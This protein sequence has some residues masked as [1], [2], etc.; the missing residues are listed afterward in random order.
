MAAEIEFGN[1]NIWAADIAIEAGARPSRI[2]LDGEDAFI[3]DQL[4]YNL[5]ISDDDTLY[6][7]TG[8]RITNV[9][10]RP[11][12][13]GDTV[14]V[15]YVVEDRRWRWWETL[16]T[17]DYNRPKCDGTRHN[18]KTCRQMFDELLEEAG[19]GFF[20]TNWASEELYPTLVVREPKPV[21]WILEELCRL[22]HHTIGLNWG[23]FDLNG[24]TAV[25]PKGQG[26]AFSFD[27]VKSTFTFN[28]NE[29][30]TR[31]IVTQP[32]ILESE[33]ELDP[34]VLEADGELVDFATCS[35]APA[36]WTAEWP[37]H[38]FGVGT[39]SQHLAMKSAY[40]LFVPGAVTND[41]ESPGSTTPIFVSQ[42]H[43]AYNSVESAVCIDWI[44][45][46]FW[47]EGH[48]GDVTTVD[49]H[50]IGDVRLDGNVFQFDSPVFKVANGLVQ[51]PTL[52]AKA[53]H[54]AQ[55]ED[56]SL[57]TMSYG[58]GPE[59]LAEW[60]QP[61]AIHGVGTNYDDINN[62]LRE[63]HRILR[64][65]YSADSFMVVEDGIK[66]AGVDGKI[67]M[68]RHKVSLASSSGAVDTEIYYGWNWEGTDV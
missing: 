14:G 26:E 56:G 33:I 6:T 66:R 43:C 58:N 8:C 40:K 55:Y 23:F 59:V 13:W 45:G 46:D 54:Y 2:L 29:W 63:L 39:P 5:V 10:D 68:I 27:D 65:E 20:D 18:Q 47:P 36:D 57:L 38:F 44:K 31:K 17:C 49:Q 41:Q 62:Q 30:A 42:G 3:V 37:G 11:V 50:Y 25:F 4:P 21:G 1:I 60:L 48:R 19:E 64:M 9:E 28:V 22:T 7:L 12:R 16:H 34:V 24:R 61:V 35:W 51:P 52:T 53:R 67:R 15:R 32:I